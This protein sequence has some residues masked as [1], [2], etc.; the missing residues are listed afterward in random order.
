MN[1]V[2]SD[3][4]WYGDARYGKS[5]YD[6][7]RQG[8]NFMEKIATSFRISLTAKK[9]LLALAEKLSVSQTAVF[10]LAIRHLSKEENI[11]LADEE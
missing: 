3:T 6:E 5:W 1:T 9:L 8:L 10:E 11:S 7:V 2:R 4:A